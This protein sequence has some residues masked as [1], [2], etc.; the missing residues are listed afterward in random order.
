MSKPKKRTYYRDKGNKRNVSL[1]R[2]EKLGFDGAL[3]NLFDFRPSYDKYGLSSE[4]LNLLRPNAGNEPYKLFRR[5]QGGA[6]H[7]TWRPE[8]SDC[9][10]IFHGS[11]FFVE[12]KLM[13]TRVIDFRAKTIKNW[14]KF[15][16][17][18]FAGTLKDLGSVG[19]KLPSIRLRRL[20][21]YACHYVD[22]SRG[23]EQI[24]ECL[25]A[26]NDYINDVIKYAEQENIA[27]ASNLS[28]TIAVFNLTQEQ[29]RLILD[30]P[31]RARAFSRILKFGWPAKLTS[32]LLAP[33]VEDE[34]MGE[35]RTDLGFYLG[36]E[37]VNRLAELCDKDFAQ[38]R[39][40]E[41]EEVIGYRESEYG[42]ELK[43]VCRINFIPNHKSHRYEVSVKEEDDL[44]LEFL[45]T[46]DDGSDE[47]LQRQEG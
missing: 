28:N 23:V 2:I 33:F 37:N 20:W 6:K 13:L 43:P 42:A 1:A 32:I 15:I 41:T 10:A 24:D 36:Q 16:V 44:F 19:E 40:I 31:E 25:S 26:L 47:F 21:S 35:I 22:L 8:E 3:K 4:D 11:D 38:R 5:G 7:Y 30:S 27:I 9:M 46:L 29:L 34:L 18:D 12:T 17:L 45:M 14:D 39:P